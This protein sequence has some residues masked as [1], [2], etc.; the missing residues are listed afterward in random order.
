MAPEAQRSSCLDQKQQKAIPLYC[1]AWKNHGSILPTKKHPSYALLELPKL[2]AAGQEPIG[3]VGAGTMGS[4]IALAVLYQGI[5][6]LLY[7]VSTRALDDAVAYI[8]KF[9]AK[10]GLQGYRNLLHVVQELDAL[11][12]AAIIIEAVPEDLLIKQ[13][14]FSRLDLICPNPTVLAT[15]T[16]TLS[17]SAIAADTQTPE[18]AV[19]LHFFNPAPVMPLIEVV[20]GD[21]TS[22]IT[23]E[24]ALQFVERLGKTPVVTRDTPGFIVNRVSRPFFGEALRLLA[25]GVA[26]HEEI[27]LVVEQGAGFPMGPFRL[28]DL[29]GLDTSLAGMISMYD[30]TYGEPRYQPHWLQAK[31]VAQ[32]QLG[33]KTGR[34]YYD[35]KREKPGSDTL[36]PLTVQKRMGTIWVSDGSWGPGWQDLCLAGG[37]KIVREPASQTEISAGFIVVGKGEGLR[38]AVIEM[39]QYLPSDK[40]IICQ[41]ADTSVS[42][43]ASWVY[44]P[45]RLVGFDGLFSAFGNLVT[46]VPGPDLASSV[47]QE[48]EQVMRGLGRRTMWIK[49]SPGLILP[50]IVCMLT[51]EAAFAVLEQ[52]ASPQTIDLAMRLGV[53]YPQGP[54]AWGGQI[55][56]SRVLQVLEH[57]QNE[58]GE[59]RYRPAPNLRRWARQKKY[60]VHRG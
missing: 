2:M 32:N 40:P 52:V 3:I 7:D 42:E 6:V 8:E 50:R 34:G 60:G 22:S 28:M 49:E 21:E 55:G 25:E 26:S 46:L 29:I 48:V 44:H 10:R 18:R 4:G 16:S 33:K 38:E 17:I 14:I 13:A 19:G 56:F 39:D 47:R 36:R 43:I 9:L 5:P 45:T 30:Q 59:A 35:Y 20:Q 15:N 53:N 23:V 57:L 37:Y 11:S 51:N 12:P 24:R 1:D 41:S 27:D 31:K 58:Y 54:L